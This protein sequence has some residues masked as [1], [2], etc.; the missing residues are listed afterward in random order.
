MDKTLKMGKD[1]AIGSFHLFIGRLVSTLLLAVGTI[2]VGIFIQEGEYGLYTIALIPATTILLFQDWGVGSA[3]TKYC[4]RCRA[5]NKE[6]NLRKIIIAGLTFEVAT[7]LALTVLSL[8]M[9]NLIASTIFGKPES[10]FLITLASIVI[11]PTSLLTASKSIFIGF[12]RMDLNG[13]TMIC[14]A[15][16]LCVLS[17]L[18]VYLGYGALGAIVGYT[19]S[20]T[21]T[22]IIALMML[23]FVIFRK[24]SPDSTNNFSISQT[25]KPLLHYGI[26]LAIAVILGGILPQ[27]YSFMMASF[28]DVAMIGNFKIATNFAFLLTFFTVPIATVLFPAFSKLDPQNGQQLLKTVFASSVKYTA[29]F[30]VP[31]TMAM[32]GLSKPIIS[33]IYGDKWLSAPFFLT[34]YVISNLF[35]IFGSL[36]VGSL[37]TA[38]GETKMLM[39]LN[40]LTLAIG[41]PIAFLLIP[42]FGILGVILVTIVAGVPSMFISLYWI[43]KRYG[44]KAEFR[45]SAKIFLASAIVAIATYLFLNFFNTAAWIMLT[46]GSITFLAIYLA[47]APLIGAIN[48]ADV[49]NLSAMFS[50]LGIIS[51]VLKI[52]LVI[53]KKILNVRRN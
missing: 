21:A 31:A 25:L 6:G 28:V 22:V 27:F 16:V 18:L 1:S 45:T 29:L 13:L 8:L 17:P 9:A 30:L 50:G 4:A 20:M 38:L 3:M 10:A 23:Y 24:L 37:L 34:L 39:K 35:A 12:E 47:A 11:L 36:S 40:I 53:V 48:Q 7:G 26:P 2:I 32:M 19:L 51:K 42:Q 5:I 46:I 15:I 52:P 33:T 14:Q 41:I 43:W 49:N 44:T